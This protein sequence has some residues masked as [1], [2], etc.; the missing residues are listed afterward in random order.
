MYIED[1]KGKNGAA[2]V[3][4]VQRLN[5]SAKTAPRIFYITRDEERS[6]S[7]VSEYSATSGDTVLFVKNNDTD[8][9]LIV[10]YLSVGGANA[11]K[12]EFFTA[13]G[14][15]AGT[16]ITPTNLNVS[17]RKEASS[18][19][20]GNAAVTGVSSI[21]KLYTKRIPAGQTEPI[22]GIAQS[23]ILGFGDAIMVTYTGST[24]EVDVEL[25]GYFED[26]TKQ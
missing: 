21:S 14:T 6:F 15:P 26:P 16:I 25:T 2:S 10:H 7:W 17:S 8:R 24:G 9:N 11:G 3:S 19:Q 5:V 18:I 13:T 12:Y 1:G 23:V 22:I 4:A 20:Y